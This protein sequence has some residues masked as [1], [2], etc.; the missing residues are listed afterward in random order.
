MMNAYD[1]IYL[2][3]ARNSFGRMLDYA[4]YDLKYDLTEFW[5]L[6]LSSDV[7]KKLERGDVSVLAGR[8]GVEMALMVA[9]KEKIYTE[10]FYA[11]GKSS[12]YWLGWALAYYQWKTCLSF[13]Q[14]TEQVSITEML[15]M[16]SPYHEMDIQHF[17]DKL[18]EKYEARKR[19]TNLKH[20]RLAAGLSQSQLAE[21]TGIPVRTIQQYEQNQK[22]I[23]KARAEYLIALAR[24]L[25]CDPAGLLEIRE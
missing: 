21:L 7:S 9:G 11:E 17:C 16:Y 25:Y 12:E 8:S 24:A 13:S 22:D 10:P 2:E 3:A 15:R 1:R 20:K 19:Q 23:N 14:I 6:F 5:E 4:V 18:S